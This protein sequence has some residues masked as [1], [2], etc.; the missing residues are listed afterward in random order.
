[1]PRQRQHKDDAERQRAYRQRQ[2]AQQPVTPR[3][4]STPATARP[5]ASSANHNVVCEH[6][7]TPGLML[8]VERSLD[9]GRVLAIVIQQGTSGLQPGWSYPFLSACLREV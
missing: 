4:V 5:D 9:R 7:A 2:A 6:T 8:R 3:Y 1:M